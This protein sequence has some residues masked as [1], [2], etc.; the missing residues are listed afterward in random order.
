[1]RIYVDD[2]WTRCHLITESHNVVAGRGLWISPSPTRSSPYSSCTVSRWVWP[3]PPPFRCGSELLRPLSLLSF[4]RTAPRLSAC[5]HQELLQPPAAPTCRRMFQPHR[6]GDSHKAPPS[7]M[8]QGVGCLC[9]APEETTG[10]TPQRCAHTAPEKP[11]SLF[12]PYL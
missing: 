3:H 1:M 6:Y 11:S 2:F 9:S 10:E 7:A 12:S 8:C 5:P 4:G